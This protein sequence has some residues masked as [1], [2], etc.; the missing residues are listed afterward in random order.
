MGRVFV[1]MLVLSVAACAAPRPDGPLPKWKPMLGVGNDPCATY[2]ARV[3]ANPAA[4]E[5]YNQWLFGYVSASNALAPN[6]NY[7]LG[8]NDLNVTNVADFRD[9]EPTRWLDNYCAE[10]PGSPYYEAARGLIADKTYLMWY[11]EQRDQ[12]E[13]VRERSH[14]E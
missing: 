6:I 5:G 12:R 8:I 14:R 3:R 10:H 7:V 13:D 11:R 9:K 2:L 4:R 1:L